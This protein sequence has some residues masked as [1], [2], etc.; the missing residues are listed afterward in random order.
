MEDSWSPEKGWQ[1][2]ASVDWGLSPPTTNLCPRHASEVDLRL[3]QLATKLLSISEVSF[4][5]MFLYKL[6]EKQVSNG[7]VKEGMSQ[8]APT[9]DP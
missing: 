3:D 5:K 7:W 2:N 1:T 9:G 4:E 8:R 6:F